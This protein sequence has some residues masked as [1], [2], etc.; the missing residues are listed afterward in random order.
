M[1]K[2]E[3]YFVGLPHKA[4]YFPLLSDVEGFNL[5]DWEAMGRP[6][7]FVSLATHKANSGE[8]FHGLYDHAHGYK[9]IAKEEDGVFTLLTVGT[10]DIVFD[11]ES[12][13]AF[14]EHDGD[15]LLYKPAY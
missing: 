6:H 15:I 4:L 7:V 8:F 10:T 11:E 9:A 13:L 1:E 12:D 3:I 2:H 14:I 5:M